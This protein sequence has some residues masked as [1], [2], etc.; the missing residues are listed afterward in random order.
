MNI[1]LTKELEGFVHNKVKSGLYHS[2]S[3]V[4]RNSLR[5]MIEME[6]AQEERLKALNIQIQ[7]GIESLER[8]PTR[9]WQEFKGRVVKTQ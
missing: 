7:K 8:E 6:S 2:A 1:S 9:T 5:L 4:V 3:E